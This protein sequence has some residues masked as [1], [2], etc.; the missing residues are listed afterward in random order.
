MVLVI[1]A[2]VWN[3]E[4]P[5]PESWLR[6]RPPELNVTPEIVR[7]LVEVS[8]NTTFRLLPL[9]RLTPL[10]DASPASWSICVS[11]LLKLLCSVV[12]DVFVVD[13]AVKLVDASTDRPTAAVV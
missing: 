3:P 8:L 1:S 13:V 11:R 6:P 10:Y 12:R 2:S 9:S 5:V 4:L 7:E